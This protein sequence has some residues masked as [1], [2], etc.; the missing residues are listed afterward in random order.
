MFTLESDYPITPNV[1]LGP[2]PMSEPPKPTSL[3]S[4][5][6]TASIDSI[7]SM[8]PTTP[9]SSTETQIQPPKGMFRKLKSGKRKDS[10]G[11]RKDSEDVL[12]VQLIERIQHGIVRYALKIPKLRG[13]QLSIEQ[14]LDSEFAR[15]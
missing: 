3:P 10:A 4:S 2:P 13:W 7:P 6:R 5:L 15:Y 11:T 14:Y 9:V 1:D 8:P 12:Q